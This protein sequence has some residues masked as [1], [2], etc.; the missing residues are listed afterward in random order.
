M[1]KKQTK[2]QSYKLTKTEKDKLNRQVEKDMKEKGFTSK[3]AY[4]NWLGKQTDSN[5]RTKKNK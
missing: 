4:A 2:T 3:E 1:E 5:K